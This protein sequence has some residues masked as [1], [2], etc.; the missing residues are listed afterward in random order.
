[1]TARVTIKDV[2]AHAR[3]SYQT[4]SKVLNHQMQVSPETEERIWRAVQKLGYVP[5][6]RARDLRT[7]RSHMLGYSWRP[8]S[9]NQVNPILD[10][11]MHS[12]VAAADARGYHIL[13]FPHPES[14]NHIDAYRDLIRT[15]RVDGFI[16]SSIEFH[17]SRI[18]FLQH[19][20]FPFVGFG[21]MEAESN[22]FVDVDGAAGMRMATEHLIAQGHTRI[23]ALGW[24]KASRVGENRLDGYWQALRAAKLEARPAWVAH[25]PG[26]VE[27]GYATTHKWLQSK[28]P[29]TAI[30]AVTDLLAIGAM[31][32]IRDAGLSVGADVGVTGFDDIPMAEYL[33]P[34]LTSVRQPIWDVGQQVIELLVNSLEQETLAETQVILK[35]ELV[36]RQS[37]RAR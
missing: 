23:A 8:D 2:A 1:M 18:K 12:M 22:L 21:G 30:A 35:P 4:V 20:N 31:C 25:G 17:D 24:P 15:G 28:T 10:L 16:L 36:V 26:S 37:S 6:Y 11:F 14:G 3:V 32:A 9:P 5:H 34:A 13:P 27:F 29:P 19:E 33:T 7:R